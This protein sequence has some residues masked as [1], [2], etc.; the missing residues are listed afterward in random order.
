MKHLE[1]ENTKE[2]NIVSDDSIIEDNAKKKQED[3][4]EVNAGLKS[5]KRYLME[6]KGLSEQ[7]AI[8]ELNTIKEE[9]K[10]NT[11]AEY[12]PGDDGE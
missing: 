10:G 7:E 4:Q 5:K 2:I 11:F 1:Q 6:N 3:I 9:N 8:E 12:D